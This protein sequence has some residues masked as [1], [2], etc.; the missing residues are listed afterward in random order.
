MPNFQPINSKADQKKLDDHIQDQNA[1]GL[2]AIREAI[3]AVSGFQSTPGKSGS[4]GYSGFSGFSGYSGVSG[5]NGAAGVSGYSGF[6][7][8]TGSNGVSGISGYSGFSG[9]IGPAG[10][11]GAPGFSGISGFS[12]YSGQSGPQGLSGFSGVPGT[13]GASGF[14]GYS[15]AAGLSGFSGYSGISGTNGAA[16]QT[17]QSGSSG[18]S[19]YSGAS[20]YSGTNGQSGASGYSGT[21]GYSGY[22]GATGSVGSQGASGFSGYSGSPGLMTASATAPLTLTYDSLNQKITGS[23][24]LTSKLSLTGGTITGDLLFTNA[25]NY[26]SHLTTD[27]LIIQGQ[28]KTIVQ[29]GGEQQV[30]FDVAGLTV[31]EGVYSY[32]AGVYAYGGN[33]YGLDIQSQRTITA[34]G[35]IT[36]AG[37]TLS[38]PL[39]VN[40]TGMN[41]PSQAQTTIL[42]SVGSNLYPNAFQCNGAG[43]LIAKSLQIGSITATG[44]IGTQGGISCNGGFSGLG[45]SITAL[46]GSQVTSGTISKDRID[47]LSAKYLSLTIGGTITAATVLQVAGD[48]QALVI[49]SPD[50]TSQASLTIQ[51]PLSTTVGTGKA[52]ALS[53]PGEANARVQF[54]SDGKFGVGP[55]T[56]TRD[57]YL[58]R[59]AANTFKISSDGANGA[60]N[61]TVTG[62][63]S[64]TKTDSYPGQSGTLLTVGSN[65]GSMVVSSQG[66]VTA[67][68]FTC[69]GTITSNG[70]IYAGTLY[71]SG[72]GLSHVPTVKTITVAPP[73][74]NDSISF[75]DVDAAVT[76]TKV[77]CKVVGGTTAQN[78]AIKYGADRSGA[79]MTIVSSSTSNKTNGDT[80][81]TFTNASVP[82]GY[83]VWVTTDGT[84]PTVTELSISVWYN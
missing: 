72:A 41:Q 74:A 10:P 13:T 56:A 11:A 30:T 64:V 50:I 52:F 65:F 8:Q 4:S 33:L 67:N 26:I 19:G 68:G 37:A 38:G 61:F 49:K 9:Q 34:G 12:G 69:S 55:G 73:Q 80:I 71:A 81:T 6:S 45:S 29:T 14:N 1:H 79:G 25:N 46:N 84:K 15:G 54:Y 32:G 58:S 44:N 16:G 76:I 28:T 51:T 60:A 48:N 31:S 57:V 59:S 75:F 35:T 47:D 77:R 2:D 83:S 40:V 42:L 63:L 62:A 3:D 70:A 78:F 82:S 43:S 24:D 27:G 7:G 22:S 39:S 21:S 66:I 36:A 20:G 17:G 5:Q 23:V 18:F 53:V